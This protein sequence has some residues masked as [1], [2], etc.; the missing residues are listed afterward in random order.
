MFKLRKDIMVKLDSWIEDVDYPNAQFSIVSTPNNVGAQR[1]SVTVNL[2]VQN[3][4]HEDAVIFSSKTLESLSRKGVE[5]AAFKA[6]IRAYIYYSSL[7][8]MSDEK[9]VFNENR[10]DG[11]YY[12]DLLDAAISDTPVRFR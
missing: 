11:K 7:H 8:F 2:I 10:V 5:V 1:F 6:L 12:L 4:I 3:G 9:P